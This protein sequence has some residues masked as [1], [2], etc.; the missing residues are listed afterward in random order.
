MSINFV[1]LI[2]AISMSFYGH[3]LLLTH[4]VNFHPEFFRSRI[5]Y[6]MLSHRLGVN[7]KP[8]YCIAQSIL[9]N[10]E[11]NNTITI[12]KTVVV[13]PF[14]ERLDIHCVVCQVFRQACVVEST[15]PTQ[16]FY[17]IK[18]FYNWNIRFFRFQ[19]N[20]SYLFCRF[21]I[22]EQSNRMLKQ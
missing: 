9:E 10:A 4:A 19:G 16:I 14:S 17:S 20:V 18:N 11:R 7:Y 13:S 1:Y 3:F 8:Q 21:Y 5:I 22:D 6:G 12:Q 15:L 2:I